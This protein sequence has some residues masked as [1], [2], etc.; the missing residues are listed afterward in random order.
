[1]MDI[2][3]YVTKLSLFFQKE[4]VDLAPVQ[5]N[6]DHCVKDLQTLLTDSGPNE[7]LL[8]EHLHDGLYFGHEILCC[9]QDPVHSSKHKFIKKLVDNIN[10]RFSGTD[11]VTTF[12]V[13]SM[14]PL[15]F[16]SSEDLDDWGNGQIEKLTAHYSGKMEV[17]KGQQPPHPLL[18]LKL[19]KK[20]GK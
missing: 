14:R 2:I 3:L 15:S 5:V 16:L 9:S 20:N 10:D 8:K 6:V 19:L 18:I 4:N 1:M 7:Q 13:L 12:G 17:R 11:M